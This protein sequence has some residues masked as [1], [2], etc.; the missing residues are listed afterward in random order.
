MKRA[1]LER[2]DRV[3]AVADLGRL[4]EVETIQLVKDRLDIDVK[5]SLIAKRKHNMRIKTQEMWDFWRK[6]SYA[7]KLLHSRLMDEAYDSL[8]RINRQI[9]KLDDGSRKNFFLLQK[10][11]SERREWIKV[12][13]YLIS[14]IPSVDSVVRS[15]D[16][17]DGMEYTGRPANGEMANSQRV[18]S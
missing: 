14:K 16:I 13:E 8:A 2:V 6:D 11:H 5:K 3:I 4:T 17:A 1:L 18:F 9:I 7:Y 12:L 10:C 15:E